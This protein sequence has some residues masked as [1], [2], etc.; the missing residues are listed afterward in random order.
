MTNAHYPI[1]FGSLT[2]E[3]AMDGAYWRSVRYGRR[4]RVRL[5]RYSDC[6]LHHWLIL[7][8]VPW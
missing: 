5:C 1:D 4:Y 7:P 3:Q 2:H 8:V 6:H